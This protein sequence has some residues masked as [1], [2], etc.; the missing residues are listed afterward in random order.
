MVTDG[1]GF[2]GGHIQTLLKSF[3]PLLGGNQGSCSGFA[4]MCC[5]YGFSERRD[6]QKRVSI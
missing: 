2:A 3:C 6:R 5:A 4:R 1:N